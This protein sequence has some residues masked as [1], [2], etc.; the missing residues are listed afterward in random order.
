MAT[1][2]PKLILVFSGKRKSGKDYITNILH[3]RIGEKNCALL[4]LSAPLKEQY[5]KDHNL[6]YNRLLDSSTYKENYRLNMIRWSDSIREKDPGYFCR[7]SIAQNG[8]K[9]KA[10]WIISD[11]RRKTD[12]DFFKKTYPKVTYLVRIFASETTRRLRGWEFTKGVD[13]VA[14][15]CD[16]DD[17]ENWDYIISNNSDNEELEK[18]LSLIFD[19]LIQQLN[20]EDSCDS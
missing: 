8:A 15:E 3:K 12:L 18:C 13:D 20:L 5:A 14:S 4:R 9:E 17:V 11:A 16:L 2:F 1:D 6:D 19:K 7:L 10:V